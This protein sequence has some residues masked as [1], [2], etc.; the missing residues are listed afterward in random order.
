MHEGAESGVHRP[1]C[2]ALHQLQRESEGQR[3]LFVLGPLDREQLLD[4]ATFEAG[5][6]K[7][8]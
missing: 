8:E 3:L 7:D 6:G 2:A 1:V 5:L 4:R